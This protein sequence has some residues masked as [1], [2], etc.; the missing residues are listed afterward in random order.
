MTPRK[1]T[2]AFLDVT[3][4]LLASGCRVRF[5]AQGASMRPAIRNGD[6][7]EVQ[8]IEP[9]AVKRGD[10]LLYRQQHR[11]IAHRVV[12]IQ[13]EGN[14]VVGFLLRGDA[15]RA[16]DAPVKPHEV[17]GRVVVRPRDASIL[18]RLLSYLRHHLVAPRATR[19]T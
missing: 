3:G 12:D 14:Q 18:R 13:R 7:V 17:L 9:E 11:P 19:H 15:K 2:A 6:A 16:C 8:I 10:I 1:D 5:C 4:Y